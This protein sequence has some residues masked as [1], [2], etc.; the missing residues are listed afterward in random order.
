MQHL[1]S[2]I[3]AGFDDRAKLSPQNAPDNNAVSEIIEQLDP[4]NYA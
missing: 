3:E 2:I 1:Q 4:A